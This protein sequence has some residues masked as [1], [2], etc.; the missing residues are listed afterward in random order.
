YDFNT[1]KQDFPQNKSVHTWVEEHAER[2]PEKTAVVYGDTRVSYGDLNEAANRLAL[3]LMELGVQ[4]DHT[5]GILMERSPQMAASILSVWKAGGAYIPLDTAYPFLRIREILEDSGTKALITETNSLNT[6]EGE[7]FNGAIIQPAP[8]MFA[9]P[10]ARITDNPAL[11]FHQNATAYVIYTS[12][13]TG[14][15]KGAVVEHI[16]MMNHMF[17]KIRE[18]RLTEN[19]IISQNASHTFDISVWQ[20]FSALVV[21]GQTVVF[22]NELILEP[23]SFIPRLMEDAIT[24]LE[25]VPS[26]LSI[27]LTELSAPDLPFPL[28]LEYLLVTG[29]EIKPNLVNRWF[30]QYPDISMVNAYGPTE[31]SDDITHHIMTGPLHS[32]RVPIGKPI[33][34]LNIYIVDPQ[35]N[36]CPI[37]VK[38]EICVSGIGVGRGYLKDP[39]RTKE[40]FGK[41]PF[42]TGKEIRFYKTGDLGRWM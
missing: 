17:S 2:T 39:I 14:K 34:N 6:G 18:L 7:A 8:D 5:V 25:V 22:P 26:Y 41:D 1:N 10:T 30:E 40:V 42:Q 24:I 35:M 9:E 32:E 19:S 15:P 11:D 33:Q 36:P 27:L 13:S 16:G 38:G 20:F 23:Y 12:G 21:G 31:A 29:E 28:E 4:N 3:Q 37:G